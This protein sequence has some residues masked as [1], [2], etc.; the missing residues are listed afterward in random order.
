M[1]RRGS[2]N[3]KQG[4]GAI[5]FLKGSAHLSMS[6]IRLPVL[7]TAGLTEYLSPTSVACNNAG[8]IYQAGAARLNRAWVCPAPRRCS[9]GNIPTS[10]LCS[11]NS[12]TAAACCETS[13]VS[14]LFQSGVFFQ[15]PHHNKE[16]GTGLKNKI[17]QDAGLK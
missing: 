14:S 8:L 1:T 16:M 2:K 5:Y 4:R 15:V 11:G 3:I 6:P 7:P 9:Q 13:C 10:T 17:L 12:V